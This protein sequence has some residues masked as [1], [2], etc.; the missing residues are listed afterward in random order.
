MR[1]KLF[2]LALA[3]LLLF[4]SLSFTAASEEPFND[5]ATSQ[6]YYSLVAYARMKNGSSSLYVFNNS[7][8]VNN[9]TDTVGE[10]KDL[11]DGILASKKGNL[12]VQNWIDTTLTNNVASGSEW[13]VIALSQN[14]NYDFKS[15]QAALIDYLA[16]NMPRVTETAQKFALTLIATG[17]RDGVVQDIADIPIDKAG[18]MAQVF[19][20]H[21]LNNGIESKSYTVGQIKTRILNMEKPGGG[22]SVRGDSG[23]VDVTSMVLQALAPHYNE[24]NIKAAVDRAIAFLANKQNADGSFSTLGK[25]NCESTAQ[26]ITALSDLKIDCRTDQRFQKNGNTP[27]DGLKMFRLKSGGFSHLAS[28]ETNKE[29]GGSVSSPE[30]GDIN[31]SSGDTDSPKSASKVS[32]KSESTQE[33]SA[34]PETQTI[35]ESKSNN[36]EPGNDKSTVSTKRQSKSTSYKLVVVIVLFVL[37]GVF[38]LILFIIKKANRK[39]ILLVICIFAV[40]V[41]FVVF[42]NFESVSQH[43]KVPAKNNAVGTVTI[44]IRCDTVAGKT[45]SKFVPKDG[46]ILPPTKIDIEKGDTV[47]DVL[48]CAV[49]QNGIQMEKKGRGV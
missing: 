46:C 37:A 18:L 9:L 21:L 42:T 43:N 39:N 49:K 26:V 35:G 25:E 6:S 22:W 2:S 24:P 12:S 23:D 40:C 4:C 32:E 1:N 13:Y 47:Y 7:G 30:K 20:L 28:V 33:K 44:S 8:N 10:V 41:S 17:K 34:D 27:F 48:S 45:D 38:A 31:P 11:A 14:G 3:L 19:G 16:D 36:N 5:G 29:E 15:Y